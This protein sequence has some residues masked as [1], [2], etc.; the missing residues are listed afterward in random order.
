METDRPSQH[1][2]DSTRANAATGG[3]AVVI[4]IPAD[5]IR[6]F[7]WIIALL[8]LCFGLSMLGTGY[9]ITM[10]WVVADKSSQE[11]TEFRLHEQ[12][13]IRMQASMIARGMGTGDP[14]IDNEPQSPP[15]KPRGQHR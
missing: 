4:Q 6:N 12:A 11:A 7:W 13:V 8:V 2:D 5:S 3:A 1:A 10:A 9:A 14:L 15:L